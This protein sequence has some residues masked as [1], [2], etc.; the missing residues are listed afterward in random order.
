MNALDVSNF[1][2][3]KLRFRFL[4]RPEFTFLVCIRV[5]HAFTRP[6]TH[7]QKIFVHKSNI[8]IV[9]KLNIT[10]CYIQAC[11]PV[12]S[13]TSTHVVISAKSDKTNTYCDTGHSR[14]ALFLSPNQGNAHVTVAF[15]KAA[16]NGLCLESTHQKSGRH[17]RQ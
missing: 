17:S 2:S 14:L 3:T 5:C 12:S 11:W 10:Y 13:S 1:T 7:L 9:I 16:P 6:Q 8:K 15:S 4:D